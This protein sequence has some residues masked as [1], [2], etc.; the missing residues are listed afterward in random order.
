MLSF[1]GTANSKQKD[2]LMLKFMTVIV[3]NLMFVEHLEESYNIIFYFL[4]FY[5]AW[6]WTNIIIF[7]ISVWPLTAAGIEPNFRFP[8]SA[9]VTEII[10]INGFVG[11]FLSDYFWYVRRISFYHFNSM[12]LNAFTLLIR[13]YQLPGH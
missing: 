2:Y 8:N 7:S 13:V 11:S 4:S 5:P 6:H 12:H 1:G 3:A 9:K 10:L